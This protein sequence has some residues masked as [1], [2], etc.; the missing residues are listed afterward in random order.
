MGL[1]AKPKD[2]MHPTT[3]WIGLHKFG[4]G[5]KARWLVDYFMPRWTPIMPEAN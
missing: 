4:S 1:S 5:A 3:F 2:N